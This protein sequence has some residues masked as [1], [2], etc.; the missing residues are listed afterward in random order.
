MKAAKK[1]VTK[2]DEEFRVWYVGVTR[3]IQNLYLIKCNN[4]RKEFKI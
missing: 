4:K 3:T 1:S 2:R